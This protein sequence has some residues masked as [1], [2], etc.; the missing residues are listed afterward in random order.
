MTFEIEHS[1][2]HNILRAMKEFKVFQNEHSLLIKI[3]L[4][5]AII[6]TILVVLQMIGI[7]VYNK[8]VSNF[9]NIS[10]NFRGGTFNLYQVFAG[11]IF[12]ISVLLIVLKLQSE[13]FSQNLQLDTP[14]KK[15]YRL[16]YKW[17]VEEQLWLLT[18]ILFEMISI[19]R[20]SQLFEK[21][22]ELEIEDELLAKKIR[23]IKNDKVLKQAN[24]TMNIN[25]LNT[26]SSLNEN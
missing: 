18:L 2:Q 16:K 24:M 11:F 6:C 21:E 9:F 13:Q 20:L 10:I 15:I 7:K 5:S 3:L 8:M 17:I 22:E 12:F 23:T 25:N 1:L 14:E 4:Y 26:Q 19:F